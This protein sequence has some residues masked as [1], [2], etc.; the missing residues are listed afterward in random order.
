M[1]P[2]T[3]EPK[4]LAQWCRIIGEIQQSEKD[5]RRQEGNNHQ[6][7]QKVEGVQDPCLFGLT[8]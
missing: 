4:T 5:R 7:V 1:D 2:K 8:S 3:L 6:I